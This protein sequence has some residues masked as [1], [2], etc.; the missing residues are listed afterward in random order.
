MAYTEG[1]PVMEGQVSLRLPRHLL[2]V[3]DRAAQ[4]AKVSRSSLIRRIL[5][6]RFEVALAVRKER[7]I[8]R[9]RALIGSLEGGPPDLA[10]NHQ[11][12]LRELFRDRRG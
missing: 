12:Y 3:L 9:V 4:R 10:R 11:K 5:E 1:E 2:R 8:D 6:E 7:P